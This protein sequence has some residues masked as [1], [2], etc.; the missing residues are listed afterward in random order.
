M[1]WRAKGGIFTRPT[2]FGMS[3]GQLQGAG[4]AGREA[5]LPL[6]KRHWVRLVKGL[7]NNV[8]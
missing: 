7:R 6:N 5:V 2:I 8:Y 3:N 1:Q 4:E